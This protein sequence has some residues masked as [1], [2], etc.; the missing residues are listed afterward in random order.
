MVNILKAIYR[1]IRYYI[2]YINSLHY[3]RKNIKRVGKKIQDGERLTV[4][5]I[6]Q[7]IPAW[8]KLQ[9]IYQKMKNSDRFN[10]IIVCVPLNIENHM[11]L[12]DDFHND[13]YEYFMHNNYECINS[14]DENGDWVNLKSFHPDYVFHS[15]P[16]NYF[17][18]NC[19]TSGK[20]KKYAL[21]CNVLYGVNTTVNCQ[22][23]TLNSDYFKDTFC[24]FAFDTSDQAFYEKRFRQGIQLQIQKCFPYGAIG[25]EQIL[26]VKPENHNKKFKKTV[27]WTPRW[28]TD[29]VVGGSNFFNYKETILALAKNNQDIHFIIRPHPL[30]FNNFIKTGEMTKE[31]VE[32]F[33]KFCFNA[34]NID[35]DEKKEYFDTFWESDILITDNSGIIPEYFVTLK[36]IVF[37]HSDIF[38]YT[39]GLKKIIETT[40]QAFTADDIKSCF[41]ELI[42]D[43]DYMKEQRQ[44]AC[45]YLFHDVEKLSDKVLD[46]LACFK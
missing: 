16:Y 21:I 44:E 39:T 24:Y 31:E 33:K 8:N 1:K 18:P 45:K 2:L 4:L 3:I 28:S 15:R 7:Y 26:E 41:Y 10:P 12:N 5:F 36:P 6:I 30:M 29:P 46:V 22:D 14:L 19:Y 20:I 11:L 25:L 38:T 27:L 23:V 42:R 9:P 43:K 17:M 13:T 32:R 40:Y 37:C 34:S 35:L